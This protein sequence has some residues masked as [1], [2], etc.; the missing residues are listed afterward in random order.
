MSWCWVYFSITRA[1]TVLHTFPVIVVSLLFDI[2]GSFHLSL[3]IPPSVLMFVLIS[4]SVFHCTF[5]AN[6]CMWSPCGFYMASK[7]GPIA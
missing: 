5:L 1:V 6:L 3:T 2:F 7:M 4:L